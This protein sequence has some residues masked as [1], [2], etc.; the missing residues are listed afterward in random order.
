MQATIKVQRSTA[1]CEHKAKFFER[2][3]EQLGTSRTGWKREPVHVPPS[4]DEFLFR[5]VRLWMRFVSDTNLE[6]N[7]CRNEVHFVHKMRSNVMQCCRSYLVNMHLNGHIV[8]LTIQCFA[9]Q[10]ERRFA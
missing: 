6:R 2:F 1:K 10:M 8:C 5:V 3:A 7:W 9:D 4:F